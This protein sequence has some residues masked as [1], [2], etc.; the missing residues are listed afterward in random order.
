MSVS[1][2]I[3][4]TLKMT[5]SVFFLDFNVEREHFEVNFDRLEIALKRL[6]VE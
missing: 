1:R 5:L 2:L 3:L 6:L 4:S